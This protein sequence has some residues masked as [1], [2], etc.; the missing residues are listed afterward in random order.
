MSTIL[1]IVLALIGLADASY[2]TY[3]HFNPVVAPCGVGIFANCGEVLGSKYAT[4]EGI[5]IS[6]LGAAYYLS[7]IL[8]L[9]VFFKTKRW[10]LKKYMIAA[11]FFAFLFSLYLVYL[12]LFIVRAIC[13]YC[14]LSALTSTFLF[15]VIQRVFF[16]E[17]K[18]LV[19]DATGFLYKKILKPYF[20][21][22]D[23]EKVHQFM[24]RVGEFMGSSKLLRLKLKYLYSFTDS[25]LEQ[26]IAGIKFENPIGLAA[27]FD[28]DARLTQAL[29]PI[30]F[31]FQTAGTIT[32]M[33]YKGNAKPRLGR[34]PESKSLMVNKGFKSKGAKKIAQSLRG[35]NFPI[36]V[37]ISI[38]RTNSLKLRTQ[39][40]SIKDIISAFETFEK[41]NVKNAY[42]ELNISCPNLK[43]NISFYP[44]KNL[45][46]LLR[47]ID[48]LNLKKPVFVKMPIEKSDR[49]VL[50]MLRVIEKSS[51]TGVIFGNLQKNR[52]HKS[53]VK[54]EMK[55]FKDKKG[56]FSGKPCYQRSNEL[57]RLA[58]KKYKDRFVIVGCGGVFTAKDAYAKIKLGASLIQLITGMV[59]EGPQIVSQINLELLR[60][61]QKDGYDSIQKAIGASHDKNK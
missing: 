60:L 47:S 43:G 18:E 50:A 52:S 57:I 31:G 58:Y 59:F 36:P 53:F 25:M 61:L 54:K 21:S 22:L 48:K 46:E 8:A 23:A 20:F 44:P 34:L 14:M 37:G 49:E 45:A 29:G 51:I 1:I 40:Q 35:Q 15:Y 33:P 42:Y 6:M 55:K 26:K 16:R 28:Y 7:I 11:S 38:G 56:N 9:V 13:P 27:G 10:F 41:A 4:F 12:Q 5:P 39:K 19:S 17:R 24:T 3:E 2:L 32:N 30:G